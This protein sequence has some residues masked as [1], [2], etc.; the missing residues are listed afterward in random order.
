M[1]NYLFAIPVYILYLHIWNLLFLTEQKSSELNLKL[2]P[3]C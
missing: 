1:V 2:K 3:K